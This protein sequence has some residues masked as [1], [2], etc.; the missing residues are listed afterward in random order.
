M[1]LIINILIWLGIIQSGSSYT[2]EEIST[3]LETNASAIQQVQNDPV[4]QH[5]F[6]QWQN[7]QS[8]QS[9]ENG[10]LGQGNR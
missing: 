9:G 10:T 2:Q 6:E 8:I 3:L 5:N 4:L 1:S 7:N